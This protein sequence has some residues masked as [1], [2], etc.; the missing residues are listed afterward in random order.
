MIII[1]NENIV[2][3]LRKQHV[4]LP[5][6]IQ[7]AINEFID[8]ENSTAKPL[9]ISKWQDVRGKTVLFTDGERVLALYHKD[10]FRYNPNKVKV[11]DAPN[12]TLYQI[13]IGGTNVVNRRLQ[14]QDDLS[15]LVSTSDSTYFGTPTSTQY[16]YDKDWNPEVNKIYYAKLLQ[17]KHLNRYASMLE[18]AYD[19]IVDMIAQRKERTTG[20]RTLYNRMI[21]DIQRQISKIEDMLIESERDY[22]FDEAKIEKLKKEVSRLPGLVKKARD[23]M[24]TEADEY[25]TWGKR[26]DLPLDPISK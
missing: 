16:I 21:G 15:G 4:E 9:T 2:T 14:R 25:A 11:S 26:K 3:D 18:D 13:D 24:Q 10:K 1:Y 5:D 23:F 6:D 22:S 7:D 17:R 8:I 19:C 12:Y 20:K